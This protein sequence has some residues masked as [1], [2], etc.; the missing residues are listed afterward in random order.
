MQNFKQFLKEND[1]VKKWLE[2][3]NLIEE[4]FDCGTQ[5]KQRGKYLT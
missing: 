5:K 3:R 4:N 1:N 2:D